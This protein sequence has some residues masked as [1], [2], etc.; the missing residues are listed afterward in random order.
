MNMDRRP[1]FLNL[2]LIRM[3]VMAIMSIAH[4]ASGVF[5]VLAIPFFVYLLDLSLSGEQGFSEAQTILSG[6]LV[7]YGLLILGW[8]LLHH[9]LSGVRYLLLDFDIGVHKSSGRWSAWM[10]IMWSAGT[11]MIAAAIMAGVFS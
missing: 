1:V 11:A 8:G 7:K 3:S 10:V 6:N 5:L 2:F 4:R 9:L